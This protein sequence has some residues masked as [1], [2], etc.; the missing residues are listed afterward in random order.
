MQAL[1]TQIRDFFRSFHPLVKRIFRYGAPTAFG[2]YA[3][4][5]V[6][7]LLVGISG[8]G[9]RLLYVSAELFACGKECFGIVFI[10]GLL[11]Q[12]FLQAY[13]QDFGEELFKK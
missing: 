8:N 7:R 12:L 11:L 10:G 3:A 6:C 2:I 5:G 13:A 4:A 1:F 9:D